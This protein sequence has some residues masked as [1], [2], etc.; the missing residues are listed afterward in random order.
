MAADQH[1]S[2][3]SSLVKGIVPIT[4]RDIRHGELLFEDVLG[5]KTYAKPII[6]QFFIECNQFGAFLEVAVSQLV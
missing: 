1:H 6:V 3:R 2:R 4:M 5:P